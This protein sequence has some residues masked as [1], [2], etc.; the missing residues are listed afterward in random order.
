MVHSKPADGVAP[1]YD[2]LTVVV[3]P[4]TT[5]PDDNA[6]VPDCEKREA[7]P[8]RTRDPTRQNLPSGI[9]RLIVLAPPN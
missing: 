9:V 5:E 3:P 6:K 7:F 1:L 2:R 8:N 4:A